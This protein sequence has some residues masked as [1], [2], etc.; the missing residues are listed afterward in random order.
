MRVGGGEASFWRPP[1]DRMRVDL[2]FWESAVGIG[3]LVGLGMCSF[4]Q[5][6]L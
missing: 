2:I 3:W 6:L 5:R 4:L 1:S